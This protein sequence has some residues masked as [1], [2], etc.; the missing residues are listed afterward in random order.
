[1]RRHLFVVADGRRMRRCN[2]ARR[3]HYERGTE[4]RPHRR[5]DHAFTELARTI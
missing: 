3:G 2:S 4:A 5:V 1:M